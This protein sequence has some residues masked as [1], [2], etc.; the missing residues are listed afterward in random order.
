MSENKREELERLLTETKE[1]HA[2]TEKKINEIQ[3]QLAQIPKSI[4][5]RPTDEAPGFILHSDGHV[6][7]ASFNHTANFHANCTQGNWFKT[8]E[9][10]QKEARRRALVKRYLDMIAEINDGW[11]PDWSRCLNSRAQLKHHLFVNNKSDGPAVSGADACY[12]QRLPNAFYCH[13][14]FHADAIRHFSHKELIFILTG[15]EH[16]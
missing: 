14:H 4:V 7:V 13:R 10:G 16:E 3:A 8:A 11:K 5:E 15:E 1:L 6:Q 9:Q 12:V 2:Q